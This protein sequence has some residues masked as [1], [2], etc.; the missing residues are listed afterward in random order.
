MWTLILDILFPRRC[1]SCGEKGRLA[2]DNCLSKLSPPLKNKIA[3]AVWSYDEPLVRKIIWK[4][5][6]SGLSSLADELSPHLLNLI[7]EEVSERAAFSGAKILVIPVPLSTKRQKARGYNQAARL[8][9]SLAKLLPDYLDYA[10]HLLLKI[11]DTESQVKMKSRAARLHNLRGAFTVPEPAKIEGRN[12]L[13]I[14]DVLT[15]GATIEE[16]TKTLKAAGAGDTLAAVL[17]HGE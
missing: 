11:K 17:A 12:I 14:D 4:L 6:Y 5:K 3:L 2:C 8:A 7:L 9:Q 1:L 10:P 13:I 15:T 16:V